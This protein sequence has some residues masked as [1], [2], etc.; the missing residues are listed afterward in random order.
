MEKITVDAALADW[1][2]TALA[3]CDIF[4]GLSPELLSNLQARAELWALEPGEVLATENSRAEHFYLVVEGQLDVVVGGVAVAQVGPGMTAGEMGILLDE[5]RSATLRAHAATSVVAF[6]A[7]DTTN[8]IEKLPSFGASIARALAKRLKNANQRIP[9][10]LY[11]GDASRPDAAALSMLP[12]TF[13][14]RHRVL[15]LKMEGNRLLLGCVADL[16][17]EL[18]QNVQSHI[19]SFELVPMRITGSALDAALAASSAALPVATLPSATPSATPHVPS[20]PVPP[21][22]PLL[23]R[24]IAEGASDLHLTAKQPPWWR[25]SGDLKIIPETEV[26]G[27]RTVLD[28]LLPVMDERARTT[29]EAE[30]DV[31]F[32]YPVEGLA[33]FRVNMFKDDSGIGA[34]L[35]QIPSKILTFEQLGLPPAIARMCDQPRGLVLVTGPTGSGKSTTLAAMIDYINRHRQA[36]ILTMEDPVEFVHQ[37]QMSLVNQREVGTHTKSF[38]R[39]LKAALRED[40]DIVLVGELRDRETVHLA[41]E[42]ANT[43]H[44]VFATLHTNTAASTIDRIVDL[45]P[46]EMHGAVRSGLAESL[47]GVICQTLCKRIGGGRIAALEVLVSTPAINHLIR[48]GRT[49][50]IAGTMQTGKAVGMQLLNEELAQLV[51]NKK[52]DAEEAL[53]RSV[54]KDDLAKRIGRPVQ[55]SGAHSI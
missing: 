14:R 2:R 9:M 41:L 51:R 44:L 10:P 45:F 54:D 26:L 30:N 53:G 8:L 27:P 35:R 13:V 43:G 46:A 29:F 15:P 48:D 3:A 31:D 28:M 47:R 16:T 50:Q 21:L 32:A 1:I 20:G 36:H 49:F 5:P 52:V 12:F 23:R 17:P 25:T 33:R 6:S 34:V 37:S 55:H 24:M 19:P 11:E 18:L 22:V 38:A 7:R 40:P 39:A 4:S 42:T